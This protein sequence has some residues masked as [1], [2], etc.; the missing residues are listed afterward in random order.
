[1]R[2]GELAARTGVSVRLLRYYE[3]QGLL[4]PER[5]PSGY[6]VYA[7]SDVD[8][9]ARVRVLLAAGLSTATIAQ[10]LPCVAGTDPVV[11]ICPDMVAVLRRERARIDT[12]IAALEASR[13][14][15]D[16]VIAAVP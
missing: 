5:L 16:D 15:L 13:A 1:M 10:V 3:E 4:Q 12:S 8:T 14:L 11:P 2:I 7:E 9:V 6:R